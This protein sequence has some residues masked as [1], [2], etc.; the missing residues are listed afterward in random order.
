MSIAPAPPPVNSSSSAEFGGAALMLAERSERVDRIVTAAAD[1]SSRH[2]LAQRVLAVGGYGRRQLFPYSDVDVLIL[3]RNRARSRRRK[4]RRLAV[5]ANAVGF[6]AA[7]QPFRAH[8]GRMPGSPRAEHRAER[9]PARPALSRRQPR[10]LC[11]AR[12]EAAALYPRQPRSAHAQSGAAGT[13]AARQV[14]QHHSSSGAQHQGI[15]RRAARLPA[16]PLARAN[17]GQQEPDRP[18]GRSV[19][20]LR[21]DPRAFCICRPGATRTCSPSMRRTRW[22]SSGTRA[23][24]RAQ[25]REYYRHARFVF[26]AAQQALERA[27]R[28]TARSFR[29]FAT[30]WAAWKTPS[31]ASTASARTSARRCSL[32]SD[33]ELALRLFEFTARHGIRP[34]AEAERQIEARLPQPAPAFRRFAAD[35]ARDEPHPLASA[36]AAGLARHARIGR[37]HRRFP[38]TRSA[39]IAW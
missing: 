7:R 24:P 21:A 17:C 39:S 33:P 32:E 38:G 8:A 31:S 10:A 22:P 13:P 37:A 3:F 5:S 12:R 36:R 30:G 15:A 1:E 23:M 29:N 26:R 11:R 25:M 34:S 20:A 27:R 2:R 19:P 16:R 18:A 14:R 35:L 9:E 4:R 6:R 28:K